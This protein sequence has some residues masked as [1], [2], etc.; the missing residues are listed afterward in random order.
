M[1]L[2]HCFLEEHFAAS[3]RCLAV[4][5]EIFGFYNER[6]MFLAHNVSL[7]LILSTV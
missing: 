5:N 2:D 7:V 4:C 3:K 1:H 6:K